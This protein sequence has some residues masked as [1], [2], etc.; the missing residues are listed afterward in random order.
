MRLTVLTDN[1]T[2]I[3]RYYL[4]EPALCYFIE[5]GGVR[6]LFD[7]GYSD[8]AAR[9][10]EAMGID[11]TAL[12]C[13]VLSH[14]HNDHTG[15]LLRLPRGERP[16]RLVAHP[17]VFGE[18]RAG[19]LSVGS[20][21]SRGQAAERFQL[22][23]SREPVAVSPAL[24]FLG[25]IPRKNDFEGAPVGE[26]L[27]GGEWKP[28]L[29]PDDSALACRTAEGLVIITGCSHAGLCNILE[30]A[31]AVMKEARVRAVIG[32]FH[33]FGRSRQLER[34]MDYLAGLAPR[35]EL[36]PCHC[37]DFAARCA[38]AERLPVHEVGVGLCL[39]W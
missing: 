13:V 30:R 1:N 3:D 25:E 9:N 14:G 36:Y 27:R 34:T 29:L 23:L 8:V 28:D 12:D 6:L 15:G 18:R 33:L 20:P 21:C 11:L 16:A 19:G 24:M 4:G 2:Y 39:E 7:T 10:A 32:G 31:R 26:A 5:D 37:T 35:P 17:R 22:R 38:L